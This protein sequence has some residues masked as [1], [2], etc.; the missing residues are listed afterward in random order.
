MIPPL[1]ETWA[2][3]IDSDYQ[4]VTYNN[5]LTGNEFINGKG[6]YSSKEIAACQS[7]EIIGNPIV[8]EIKND[9]DAK[10]VG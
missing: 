6:G 1:L 3:P 5:I 2:T 8:D 4:S 7:V 10:V 9:F